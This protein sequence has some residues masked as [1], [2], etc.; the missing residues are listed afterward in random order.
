MLAS[1]P[2]CADSSDLG[3]V[4]PASFVPILEDNGLIVRVGEWVGEACRE[5]LAQTVRR[6]YPWQLQLSGRRSSRPTSIDASSVFSDAGVD[7]G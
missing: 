6:E 7:P 3:L 2:C 1:K 5:P 4:S